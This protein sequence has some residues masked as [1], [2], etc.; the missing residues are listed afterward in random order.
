MR[1]LTGLL[2][3]AALAPSAVHAQ[4]VA[5]GGAVQSYSMSDAEAVRIR[6]IGLTSASFAASAP[7]RP[8][9]TLSLDGGWASARVTLPSGARAEAAGLVDTRARLE[10]RA[11]SGV[12]VTASA[13][14]PTGEVA[15]S[16]EEAYVVGLLSTDLFPF[17]FTHW[18]TGGGFGADVAYTGQWSG[19]R[20]RLSAGGLMLSESEPLG[21]EEMVHRPGSQ[22]R[23]QGALEAPVGEAGV[24]SALVGV[25]HFTPDTYRSVNLFQAG[26][27]LEGV[28]SYGFALGA[29]ESALAY[30]RFYHLGAG[31]S[32]RDAADIL[33]GNDVLAGMHA[34]PSRQ[35]FAGG[36]ELRVS[37]GQLDVMPHG[38]LRVL[39]RGDGRGQGWLAS[40]GVR[41]AVRVAGTRMGRRAIVEPSLAVRTGRLVAGEGARSGVLGWEAGV[42]LRWEGGR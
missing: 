36:T 6:D 34:Q 32:P 8:W 35:V 1:A 41:G 17:A 12:S 11:P 25:Q 29:R 30:G 22:I 21:A 28:L 15:G 5:V 4:R 16:L 20:M 13:L 27:R 42:A 3:L 14:L 10:L 7:V 24:V 40:A 9:A 19:V 37:R 38:D 18:G 33:L 26:L 39:R 23:A 31:S 2:V